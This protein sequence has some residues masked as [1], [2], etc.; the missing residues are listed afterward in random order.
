MG[1][2]VLEVT[3]DNFAAVRLYQRLGWEIEGTQYK[4]VEIL[5][6]EVTG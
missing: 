2:A 6:R 5:D 3:A 4:S 1:Q